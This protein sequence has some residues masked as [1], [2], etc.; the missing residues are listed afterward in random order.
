MKQIVQKLIDS[1]D[2]TTKGF[3]SRKLTAFIIVSCVIAAHIKWL[4]IGDLTQ[5]GEV[6]IIDYTFI[7][8][9][10]GM[11]TYQNLKSKEDTPQ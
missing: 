3:S 8:A 7:A 6:F 11:T 10:F 9:L 5:L 4:S 2:T 1:F